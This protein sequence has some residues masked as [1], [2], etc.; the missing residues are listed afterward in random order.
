MNLRSIHVTNAWPNNMNENVTTQ[1]DTKAIFSAK[2]DMVKSGQIVEAVEKFFAPNASTVDFDGSVTKT[3]A[4]LV[5]KMQGFVGSIAKV[6]GI[7]QHHAAMTGNVSFTECTFDFTMKD[8]SSVLWHEIL[9][10]VWKDG[11]IVEEQ[12]FKA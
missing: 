12:Y 6:N 1:M 8:G 5:S 7:T 9:R 2:N 3:K 11:L 10:A 4:E